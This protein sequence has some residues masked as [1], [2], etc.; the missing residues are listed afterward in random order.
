M[1]I[2]II[3]N[4]GYIGPVLVKHLKNINK[5]YILIGVDTGYFA[6][7]QVT[8]DVFPDRGISQQIF[9]DAREIEER[10]FENIDAII[11]LAAISNDPMGKQFSKQTEEINQNAA[12]RIVEKAIK[13]KVKSFIF[14]SS[15]SVYGFADGKRT[16][17]SDLNPITEYA[18]SKINTENALKNNFINDI[19]I[20]CLRFATACGY[21][22]RIRLDLVLNDFVASALATGK[23]EILSDGSPWRPL[24]HVKDMSRAIEWACIRNGNDFISLNV[25]S[26]EWNYKIYDLATEVSRNIPNTEVTFNKN[27]S[28]DNRSYQVDFSK[29]K[30]LAPNHQPLMTL[31]ETINEMYSELKKYNFNEGQFRKSNRYIRLNTLKKHLEENRLNEDLY[32]KNFN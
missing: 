26:D 16:E 25:G 4:L 28:K 17:N 5:D 1:K 13:K 10:H 14:A 27:A 3:G 30:Y 29:F 15:C 19:K 7:N 18:K 8:D 11:Y 12:L 2:L 9:V 22:P 32:W 23:I 24:I 31:K 20:T 21:S 6:H